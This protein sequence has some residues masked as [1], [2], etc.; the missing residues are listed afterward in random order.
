MGVSVGWGASVGY[1]ILVGVGASVGQGMSVAVG[2]SVGHGLSVGVA[3]AMVDCVAIGVALGGVVGV[4]V[5][6]V[7]GD[8]LGEAVGTGTFVHVDVA[9]DVGTAVGAEGRIAG[10]VAVARLAGGRGVSDGMATG[11]L[12]GMGVAVAPGTYPAGAAGVGVAVR[13][14]VGAVVAVVFGATDAAGTMGAAAVAVTLALAARP[15]GVAV[16]DG[17]RRVTVTVQAGPATAKESR[18]LRAGCMAMAM[19]VVPPTACAATLNATRIVNGKPMARGTATIT[20]P[21]RASS[22]ALTARGRP[23]ACPRAS[24]RRICR[25]AQQP[26]RSS[27][28]TRCPRCSGSGRTVQTKVADV[29]DGW[30]DI[31][32]A[33]GA[34]RD[35][36]GRGREVAPRTWD[37]KSGESTRARIATTDRRI[38]CT[39]RRVIS[40]W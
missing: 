39:S 26:N 14:A 11:A 4:Q 8:G 6:T 2:A 16:G 29:V 34:E 23:W 7:G 1:G 28:D 20:V 27:D 9:L 35:G 37:G 10:R 15:M 12:G 40:G 18:P 30:G 25:V 5:G 13:R 32:A 24:T 38:I 36:C 3:V 22:S 21:L 31:R 33:T 17:R 19:R